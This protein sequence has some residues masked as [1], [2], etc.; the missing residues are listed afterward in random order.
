MPARSAVVTE[1][2][3]LV[4]DSSPATW[5]NAAQF[6]APGILRHG[7][8][9]GLLENSDANNA[10]DAALGNRVPFPNTDLF[11]ALDAFPEDTD[12][13][14]GGDGAIRFLDW[15]VILLRSLGLDLARWERSWSDGGVR[16]AKDP[17]HPPS[18]IQSSSSPG[19]TLSSLPGA[20]WVR[21]AVLSAQTMEN[22]VPGVAVDVPVFV[23]VAPG[24][25]VAGMAFRAIVEPDGA[26]PAVDTPVQFVPNPAMPPPPQNSD[27]APNTMLCGWPLVPSSA[28]DP[29]LTGSNLL[30]HI[31]VTLP[32]GAYVGQSYTL[33]FANADGAP[34]LRTQYDFD[35]KT[36]SLW[37]WSRAL[38][39]APT[40]SD[41]WKVHFFGSDTSDNA[42]DNA[43][44]DHDGVP[45]W[46]EYLAG[47]D[48]TD[49]HSYLHLQASSFDPSRKAVVLRW[50]S[51]PGK[52]YQIESSPGLANP[53]WSVLAT[54]L[55]GDGT[56]QQWTQTNVT[57]TT[58]FYRVGLQP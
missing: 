3:Y 41:E 8:G 58:Q 21:Q 57:S 53:N 32:I 27:P 50:L 16:I 49:G 28:F 7:F 4:G 36:A 43:D 34:D 2:T 23:Q 24:Y 1:A 9:D 22:V 37:V 47:T 48:P 51:A 31:R 18:Q 54:N 5:Y 15:Q 42:G 38:R 46:A 13:A 35:T 25:Q 11:D 6:D 20:V 39:P 10:F 52:T 26:A 56:E 19:Q 33:R 17:A 14:V 44:P 45:N 30:G 40:A 29:P 55:L 12:T